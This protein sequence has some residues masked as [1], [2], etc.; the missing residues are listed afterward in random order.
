MSCRTHPEN[1]VNARHDPINLLQRRCDTA[2]WL[3][4]YTTRRP[5]KALATFA[6]ITPRLRSMRCTKLRAHQHSSRFD[7]AMVLVSVRNSSLRGACIG[8]SPRSSTF[9]PPSWHTTLQN[10]EQMPPTNPPHVGCHVDLHARYWTSATSPG[11]TRKRIPRVVLVLPSQ[12]L[13]F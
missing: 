13:S 9:I 4:E 8:S 1:I 11:V 5:L 7:K 10:R 2:W 12:D 3:H 6:P